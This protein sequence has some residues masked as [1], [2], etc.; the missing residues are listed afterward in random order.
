MIT[1]FKRKNQEPTIFDQ[2]PRFRTTRPAN[3]PSFNDWARE[4]RVS[5]CFERVKIVYIQTGSLL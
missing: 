5:S 2:T 3:R 1:L 4:Y